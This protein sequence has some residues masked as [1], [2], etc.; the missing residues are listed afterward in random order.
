MTFLVHPAK[1]RPRTALALT[2]GLGIL[3]QGLWQ[4]LDPAPAIA[5]WAILIF[6]LRDFFAP[7]SYQLSDEGVR[8]EGLLK[9]TKYYPW[10]RFRAYI[11]DRNGIFL[12]PYRQKRATENQRGVFLPLNPDQRKQFEQFCHDIGLDKRAS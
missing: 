8:V 11:S 2:F 10:Q 6:S 4:W 7:T 3:L 5:L 9:S 12:T 1:D